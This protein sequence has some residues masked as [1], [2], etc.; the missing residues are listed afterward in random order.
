VRIVLGVTAGQHLW[1]V[2]TDPGVNPRGR[3]AL[4]DFVHHHHVVKN[5]VI[6]V[7]GAAARESTR[8]NVQS[9]AARPQDAGVN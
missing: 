2:S 8:F 1:I 3:Q 6:D 7:T 4:P 9:I 5:E